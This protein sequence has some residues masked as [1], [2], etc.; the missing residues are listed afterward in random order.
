MSKRAVLEVI[1]LGVEDAIAAREIL[2]QIHPAAEFAPHRQHHR[3]T[4][5][6]IEEAGE[7]AERQRGIRS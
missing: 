1:A 6:A 5:R 2:P 3:L 7:V 4:D